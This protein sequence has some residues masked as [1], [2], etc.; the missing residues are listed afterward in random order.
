MLNLFLVQL[1][2][3]VDMRFRPFITGLWV[4]I[5]TGIIV[6]DKS[7][8]IDKGLVWDKCAFI[9]DVFCV[10]VRDCGATGTED[11]TSKFCS[12]L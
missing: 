3:L 6:M 5:G 11:F 9:R 7:G 12:D 4:V 8:F 2:Q 1:T 10:S